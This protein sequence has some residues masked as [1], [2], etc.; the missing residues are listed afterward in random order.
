MLNRRKTPEFPGFSLLH[1]IEGKGSDCVLSFDAITYL[2]RKDVESF[3]HKCGRRFYA[4]RNETI[5]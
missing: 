5:W 4:G 3:E 2:N 1:C